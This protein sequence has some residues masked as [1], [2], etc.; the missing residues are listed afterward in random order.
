MQG[1]WTNYL[2]SLTQVRQKI[3]HPLTLQLTCPPQDISP[4][5]SESSLISED[6]SPS[7]QYLNVVCNVPIVVP[8]PRPYRSLANLQ[9]QFD[10]PSE[11]QDLSHPPY[12]TPRS[13]TKRKRTDDDDDADDR[14]S[15]TSPSADRASKKRRAF[16]SSCHSLST[17]SVN[18]GL[19]SRNPHV[20]QPVTRYAPSEIS[21]K[22]R[23]RQSQ[24]RP[25]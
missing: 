8:K 13:V 1:Q 19:L 23:H 9:L 5:P 16:L 25:R 10:L 20:S 12:C 17:S 6:G 18:T 3:V 24:G 7:S 14:V 22:L 15:P 21:N 4:S 11:D 2:P